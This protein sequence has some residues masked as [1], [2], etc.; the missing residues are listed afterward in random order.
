MKFATRLLAF[1]L[2][3]AIPVFA[4]QSALESEGQQLPPAHKIV[5][6]FPQWG[7]YGGYYV[8]NVI[9]SGSASRRLS[10]SAE[11]PKGA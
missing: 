10:A 6:Y 3:V 1:L 11:M 4:Q 5:G 7:V 2:F 8:K 9:T